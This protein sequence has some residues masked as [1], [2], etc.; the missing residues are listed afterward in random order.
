MKQRFKGIIIYVLVLCMVLFLFPYSF[1]E[2]K[3]NNGSSAVK[4]ISLNESNLYL[5]LDQSYELKVKFTPQNSE[6]GAKVLWTTSDSEIVTVQNGIVS[7]KGIGTAY[8]YANCDTSIAYCKITVIRYNPVR[9]VQNKNTTGYSGTDLEVITKASEVIEKY[10]EPGMTDE[11]KI[12]AIQDYLVEKCKYDHVN[13]LNKTVPDSENGIIGTLV[14]N[15]AV[16]NGY[17]YTFKYFMDILGIEARITGLQAFMWNQVY[18]NGTWYV[19]NISLDTNKGNG[20]I[21][22][23]PSLSA[24]LI[25]D[26]S[27]VANWEDINFES[28]LLKYRDDDTYSG[29]KTYAKTYFE[30]S[31]IR[32]DSESEGIKEP[33]FTVTVDSNYTFTK[34]FGPVNGADLVKTLNRN[35]SF[36]YDIV[37]DSKSNTGIYVSS[38]NTKADGTGISYPDKKVHSINENL[39]LYCIWTVNIG[40]TKVTLTVGEGAFT[41]KWNEVK[42]CK[43]YQIRYSA[44]SSMKYSAIKSVTGQKAVITG[45]KKKTVYYVQ[46]RAYIKDDNGSITYGRWSTKKQVKTS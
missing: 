9:A 4:K 37:P 2:A 19:V 7:A 3:A 30:T 14:K 17:A 40:Q 25:V 42:N 12:K 23:Q 13:E 39:Y 31:G 36:V 21:W 45:L 22:Y 11:Q 29:N 1:A 18:L 10:I 5:E 16:R 15:T 26:N 28:V 35:D 41:S 46:I 33:E 32:K 43:D 20:A 27:K 44:D 6:N 34:Q 8:V 38:L 24:A